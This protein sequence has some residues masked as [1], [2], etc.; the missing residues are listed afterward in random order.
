MMRV[1]I[2]SYSVLPLGLKPLEVLQWALEHGAEGVQ[3]SGLSGDEQEWVDEAYLRDMSRFA[4]EHGLYLEWGGG[5]H[6]PLDMQ[7][8][9]KK[10]IFEINRRAAV[11][12]SILDTRIVRSCSGG[13]MRWSRES[14]S[15]E[16]FLTEM[17][18][19]L[20]AQSAMLR[21][22][23]VILALETHFEFTTFELLR[24]FDMCGAEPGDYLGICLDTM[25]LLTMLEDPLAGT[26]RMLPWVVCTHVKDGGILLNDSGMKT[27]PCEIGKGVVDLQGI[28][29]LLG[30]LP[31]EV[32]LSI[33]DHGG[34]FALP[35]FETRFLS[36]FPDLTVKEFVDLCRL[37]RQTRERMESGALEKT[38]RPDWPGVCEDRIIK[39]LAA[40]NR[41]AG[42][43]DQAG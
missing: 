20:K 13:L 32:H 37:T 40:L 33:E 7:T 6:I 11:Q 1:G 29:A 26:R 8:W 34:E 10:D 4:K 35:I 27:F 36:E 21:D 2:D 19:V 12:A 16:L 31:H 5:Q 43:A 39:D 9:E 23:G 18:A 28:T 14:P 42:P 15:T 17:A 38:S 41:I 25:N 24:L 22:L 3:F 30:S